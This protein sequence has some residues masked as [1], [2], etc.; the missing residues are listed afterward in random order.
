MLDDRR[1]SPISGMAR[2]EEIE[3]GYLGKMLQLTLLA[4]DTVEAVVGASR[5]FEP[6][7]NVLLAACRPCGMNNDSGSEPG[8]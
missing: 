3:R 1:Y 7:S 8:D 6:N 4:L 2:A 5:C